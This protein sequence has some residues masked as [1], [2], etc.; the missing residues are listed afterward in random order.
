MDTE[1]RAPTLSFSVKGKR[2]EEI[3]QALAKENICAWDGHFYALRAVEVLGLLEQGGLTRLGIS[4][5]TNE[6]EIQKT[7][8]VIAQI[9]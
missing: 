4:V 8:E 1:H 2:P 6:E 3:C 5:Y 9:I 7:L